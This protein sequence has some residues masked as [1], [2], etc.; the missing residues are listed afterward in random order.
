MDTLVT[1]EGFCVPREFE[2]LSSVENFAMYALCICVK[3]TECSRGSNVDI[4]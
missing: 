2:S 3:L 1:S 4:F